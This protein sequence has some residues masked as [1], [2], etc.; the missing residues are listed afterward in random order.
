MPAGS[1]GWRAHDRLQ[2][3]KAKGCSKLCTKWVLVPTRI[4]SPHCRAL[5]LL[6]PVTPVWMHRPPHHHPGPLTALCLQEWRARRRGTG[7]GTPKALGRKRD[8]A[9]RTAWARTQ[10]HGDFFLPKQSYRNEPF[11]PKTLP[12]SKTSLSQSCSGLRPPRGPGSLSLPL[13][14]TQQFLILEKD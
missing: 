1:W 8:G 4:P 5:L 11:L 9:G 10:G 12:W 3:C 7:R 6:L 14:M 13:Q 2:L